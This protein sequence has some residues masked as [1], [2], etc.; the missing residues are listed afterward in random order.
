MSKI[1]E[2]ARNNIKN[3]LALIE[4]LD[5]LIERWEVIDDY[6]NYSVSTFG[7]VK[8]VDTGL[9]LKPWIGN[10]GGYKCISLSRN[11]KS[12]SFLLHRIIAEAFINNPE[13]KYCVDHKNHNILDNNLNNLRWATHQENN[14]NASKRNTNTSGYTGVTYVKRLSKFRSRYTSKIGKRIHVGYFE[15]A[16]E[17]SDAYQKAIKKHYGAF[18]NT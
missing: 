10:N 7:R 5:K 8:N 4:K 14:R 13:N 2:N 17:A 1:F 16:E 6:D 3:G 15:T 9:I 11:N 18:A 12:K